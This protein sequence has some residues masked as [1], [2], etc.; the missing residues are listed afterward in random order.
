[1][2]EK[3]KKKKR[4]SNRRES[5]IKDK[6]ESYRMIIDH[7][8]DGIW[9]WD[10][11]TDYLYMPDQ[12]K[13]MLGYTCNE[14]PNSIEGWKSLLHPDDLN[15]VLEHIQLYTDNSAKEKFEIEYRI[16]T[17][18]GYYKWILDRGYTISDEYGVMKKA[19]GTFTDITERKEIEETLR[20]Q[21]EKNKKL[22]QQTINEKN[23][24]T[25]MFSNIS[26]EFKTPLNVI[27][28]T[29]QLM[30]TML[31]E[32][33]DCAYVRKHHKYIKIMKQNCYRLLRL[34]NNIIDSTKIDAG[35][36]KLNLRNHNIVTIVEN[37]A[38]SVVEYIESKA[39]TLEFDTEI[40]EKIMACD[41]EKMERVILNLLSNAVKYTKSGG[42]I[43]VKI[44][45][46][47]D[48]IMISVKDT[49]IGVPKDK[50]AMI[51]KRFKGSDMI[52]NTAYEGS[53]IGLSLVKAIVYMHQGDITVQSELGKGSEFI[54]EIPV[55][56]MKEEGSMIKENGVTQYANVEKIDIE[57]SDIYA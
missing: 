36:F 5:K 30:D 23:Q 29:I 8:T 45:D 15:K 10:I 24:R 11:T 42:S 16:K 55:R 9:E 20:I 7:I 40:E 37:I 12:W 18:A 48:K 2:L 27:L 33:S 53:G 1:M 21:I 4:Q 31:G 28:G 19:V 44:Y 56:L 43:W 6:E 51:F 34:I 41:A 49:G 47:K 17:K 25:E 22:L 35:Y 46:K 13:H 54:I 52:S 3:P 57:F 39:I 50:Q 32:H 14:I 26:H 38:L